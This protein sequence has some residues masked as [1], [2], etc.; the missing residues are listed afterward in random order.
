MATKELGGDVAL[1]MR[2]QLILSDALVATAYDREAPKLHQ[3]ERAKLLLACQLRT[4][5]ITG[6]LSYVLP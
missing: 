1:A 3:S 5:A 4:P 2:K 6:Q